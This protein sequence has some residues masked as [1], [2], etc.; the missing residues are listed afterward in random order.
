MRELLCDILGVLV[1]LLLMVAGV[2]ALML[3]FRVFWWLGEGIL[4]GGWF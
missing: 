1:V 4:M 2:A 3:M